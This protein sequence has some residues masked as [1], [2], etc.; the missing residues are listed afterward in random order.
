MNSQ[1]QEI[2]ELYKRIK[3]YLLTQDCLYKDYIRVERSF[4]QKEERLKKQLRDSEDRLM[5][6]KNTHQLMENAMK[7]MQSGSKDDM[8]FKIMEMTKQNSILENNL[9]RLTR[10]YQS[11]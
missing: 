6:Q 1:K 9:M 7:N 4:Y 11:L 3:N 2:D 8:K 5:E 10:K